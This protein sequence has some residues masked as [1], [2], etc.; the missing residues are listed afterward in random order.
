M[1]PEISAAVIR[2]NDRYGRGDVIGVVIDDDQ[3]GG[4]VTRKP[5]YCA[6]ETRRFRLNW[7]TH[8]VHYA[9]HQNKF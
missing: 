6:S 1:L 5:K 9:G 2:L 8:T 3:Q 7:T 4:I